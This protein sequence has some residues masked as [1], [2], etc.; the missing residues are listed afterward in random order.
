MFMS[1]STSTQTTHTH[2]VTTSSRSRANGASSSF[3][4]SSSCSS[5]TGV[6][7]E[8]PADLPPLHAVQRWLA[9]PLKALLLPTSALGCTS[10][11]LVVSSF[12]VSVGVTEA[13]GTPCVCLGG[14]SKRDGWMCVCVCVCL[15]ACATLTPP[16]TFASVT[17]KVCHAQPKPCVTYLNPVSRT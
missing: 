7:L 11:V 15:G 10:R 8:V 16:F 6:A 4:S 14:E 5:G 17:D 2:S 3:S 1:Y 9:Q 12:G 13:K